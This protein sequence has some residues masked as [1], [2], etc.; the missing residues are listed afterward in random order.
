MV[1]DTFVSF[2]L[3]LANGTEIKVD[4]DNHSD[5]LWAMKGAGH[6]FGI[7]TSFEL[8]IYPNPVESWYHKF[9]RFSRDKLEPIFEE[10]NKLHNNGTPPVEMASNYGGFWWDTTVSDTEVS[11]ISAST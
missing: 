8:K 11:D 4:S 1:S 5:L 9:Y 10:L 3:V 2:N 7:V 6:N